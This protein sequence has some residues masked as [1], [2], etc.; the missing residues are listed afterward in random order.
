M[1]LFTQGYY[2]NYLL[3]GFSLKKLGVLLFTC[4]LLFGANQPASAADLEASFCEKFKGQ[5]KIWWDGAELKPGQIGRLTIKKDTPLFKLNGEKKAFSRTLKAGEFYRFYAFKPGLLSVGGG[6]YVTR[7]VKVTYQTPSKGKLNA[8]KCIQNSNSSISV[9]YGTHTYGSKT[10]AE[11]DKVMSIVNARIKSDYDKVKFS[12]DAERNQ[13]YY[14]YLDGARGVQDRG[15]SDFRTKRN[16]ALIQAEGKFGELVNA[17]FSKETIV[18]L[19]KGITVSASLLMS[20]DDPLDGTP[21]SAYDALVRKLADCDPIAYVYSAVFDSLGYNT[22][23]VAK[24]GHAFA[25][26][27]V[28]GKW[29]NITNGANNIVNINDMLVSGLIIVTQPTFG[30]ILK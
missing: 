15:N 4:M 14:E 10:Q 6:Y 21:F 17:G 8:V 3:G 7:D 18:E 20:A 23:V 22:V 11:Y 29:V 28:D 9:S 25:L 5:K 12:A 1:V 30:E 19:N 26:V 13:Y 16:I 2:A 24:P 27:Q